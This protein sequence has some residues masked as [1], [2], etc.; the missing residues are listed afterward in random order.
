[1]SLQTLLAKA[2]ARISSIL[3][4]VETFF[5]G[6]ATVLESEIIPASI[7]VTNLLKGITTIDSTDVIG[8]LVKGGA[9]AEDELRAILPGVLAD[10]QIAKTLENKTPEEVM[11]IVLPILQGGASDARTQLLVEFEATLQVKLAASKGITTGIVEAIEL[12]QLVYQDEQAL[13]VTA[14]ETAT[15]ETTATT[16]NAGEQVAEERADGKTE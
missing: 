15:E 9:I 12:G 13:A 7:A 8:G 14:T 6:A 4:N 1:M 11:A 16:E 3:T 10:L 5:E 2:Q